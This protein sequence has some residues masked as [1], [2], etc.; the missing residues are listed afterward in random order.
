MPNCTVSWAKLP[1]IWLWRHMCR[2]NSFMVEE[3]R[4]HFAP[5]GGFLTAYYA[6]PDDDGP[7]SEEITRSL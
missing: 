3:G 1:L 7:F 5:E 6:H 4:I 2:E